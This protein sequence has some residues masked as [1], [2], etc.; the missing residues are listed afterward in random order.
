MIEAISNDSEINFQDKDV[1]EKTLAEMGYSV[2]YSSNSWDTMLH[3]AA[4]KGNL[5]A[6]KLGIAYGLDRDAVNKKGNTIV[7]FAA[8]KGWMHIL[9]YCYEEGICLVQENHEGQ[10]PY[11]LALKN[12]RIEATQFF[13]DHTAQKK[14]ELIDRL[15]VRGFSPIVFWEEDLV[16]RAIKQRNFEVL[17]MLEEYFGS[18]DVNRMNNKGWAPIHTACEKGDIQLVSVLIG[19]GADVN[20]HTYSPRY[21]ETDHWTWDD[22]DAWGDAPCATPYCPIEGPLR[23]VYSPLALAKDQKLQELLKEHGATYYYETKVIP[24]R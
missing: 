23:P 5:E 14:G 20:L 7:H 13:L 15:I 9:E 19:F 12:G 22:W 2:E 8:E 3:L 24:R 4:K 10:T 6:L 1:I 16:D 21:R 17:K 11:H 18:L